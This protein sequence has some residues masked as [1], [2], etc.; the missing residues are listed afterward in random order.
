MLLETDQLVTMLYF[1]HGH[2]PCSMKILWKSPTVKFESMTFPKGQKISEGNSGIYNPPQNQKKILFQ[3]LLLHLKSGQT[4][5]KA[6]FN[7]SNSR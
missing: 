7:M 2:Q 6:L 4:I 3:F 1:N 5:R